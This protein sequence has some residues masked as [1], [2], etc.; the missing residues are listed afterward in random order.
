MNRVIIP[1]FYAHKNTKT[2]VKIS[3]VIVII[4]II[5]NIILMQFLQHAGLALATTISAFI[6]LVLLNV[7]LRKNYSYIRVKGILPSLLKIIFLTI[8]LALL[9]Y[10]FQAFFPVT[11][12]LWM[13]IRIILFGTGFLLLYIAGSFLFNIEYSRETIRSVWKKIRR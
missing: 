9:L 11:G 4:N 13:L 5:L 7:Y 10:C 12:K 2:P 6:H 1:I 8:V 3:A